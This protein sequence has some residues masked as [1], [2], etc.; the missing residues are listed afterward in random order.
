MINLPD[1][2]W[3]VGDSFETERGLTYT[4]DGVRWLSD[5]ELGSTAH[6]HPYVKSNADTDIRPNPDNRFVSLK[7]RRF[8]EEDGTATNQEFGLQLD[9]A[10]GNT[11][12]NQFQVT[13]GY[14]YA[15]KVLGGSGKETWFGGKVAQKGNSLENDDARD[16]IIRKNLTDAT[17]TLATRTEL[18]KIK[19]V[20]EGL[21][22]AV[23]EIKEALKLPK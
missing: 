15:L 11:Y 12:K 18:E 21:Q 17:S 20:V 16:Y 23:A 22:D 14:G 2:P 6:D 1:K 7:T 4:F 13:T 8:Q 5:G 9:L 10:E 19:S 3:S